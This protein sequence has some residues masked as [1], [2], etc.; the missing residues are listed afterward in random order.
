MPNRKQFDHLGML[1][2]ATERIK[3]ERLINHLEH[4]RLDYLDNG[5]PVLSEEEL[6]RLNCLQNEILTWKCE[7]ANKTVELII[8]K[9]KYFQAV[10]RTHSCHI[11]LK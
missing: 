11:S 7:M 2:L 4:F 6:R 10:S 1:K 9:K 3:I 5:D 8:M